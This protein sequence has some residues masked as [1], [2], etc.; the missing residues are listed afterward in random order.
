MLNTTD[1]ETSQTQSESQYLIFSDSGKLR[2]WISES[3]N[4]APLGPTNTKTGKCKRKVGSCWDNSYLWNA[5]MLANRILSFLA[6]WWG[7]FFMLRTSWWHCFQ[8]CSKAHADP[9]NL[10]DTIMLR[11]LAILLGQDDVSSDTQFPL[12]FSHNWNI[13]R[14]RAPITSTFACMCWLMIACASASSSA[15]A[16]RSASSLDIMAESSRWD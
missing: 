12:T 16:M 5:S 9:S 15:R 11:G 10:A 7:V 14:V 13:D 2:F 4:T 6:P 8:S 1:T 3:L